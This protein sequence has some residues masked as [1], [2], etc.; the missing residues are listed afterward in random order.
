MLAQA[1]LLPSSGP[2]LHAYL[3]EVDIVVFSAAAP[4]HLL[5]QGDMEQSTVFGE[6]PAAMALKWVEQGALFSYGP[7]F[8]AAGSTAA[9]YVDKLLKGAK[10]ADM[11]E[12]AA[13]AQPSRRGT[14]AMLSATVRC[15]N[16]P[17][18][19]MA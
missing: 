12:S 19:W 18:P 9:Q 6:D 13:L 2:A 8:R 16:R 11:P 7:N 14:V 10:P 1:A 15:G 4:H 17:R 3:A 5:K